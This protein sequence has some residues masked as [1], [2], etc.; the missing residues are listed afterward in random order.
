[1]HRGVPAAY[2]NETNTLYYEKSIPVKLG[3]TLNILTT[4]TADMDEITKEILF[5]YINTYFICM[6]VPYEVKRNIRFGVNVVKESIKKSSGAFEYLQSGT[7]YQT[8]MELSI[9]GAVE[10]SY[11]PRHVLRTDIDNIV[12]K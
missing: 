6:P 5:R 4:N 12:V 8:S 2:D 9:D 3:Y 1:M 10:L 11:T 7:L